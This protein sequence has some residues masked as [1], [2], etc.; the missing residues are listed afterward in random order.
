MINKTAQ[1]F[2]FFFL[3]TCGYGQVPIN[4]KH[5][6]VDDGLVSNRTNTVIKDSSGFMWFGTNTGLSR[7]DG[8]R[9]KTYSNIPNDR[10]SLLNNTVLNL[11]LGFERQLWVRTTKGNC[12]YDVMDDAFVWNT[13]SIL[14]A[15]GFVSGRVK[16]MISVEGATYILYESG[17]L[18]YASSKAGPRT[19]AKPWGG[20]LS[21]KITDV[22]MD[23]VRGM[24]LLVSDRGELMALDSEGLHVQQSLAFAFESLVENSDF[25]LFVDSF[26]GIWVY[27][28]NFPFG[29]LY[30]PTFGAAPE[31][32]RQHGGTVTV[33]NNYIHN[34]QQIDNTVWLATDHGGINVFDVKTRDIRYLQH[35]RLNNFSLPSNSTIT[36]YKDNDGMMWVGTYKGGV[37]YYHPSLNYF[38]LFQR[39]DGVPNS[40]PFNDVN[41]FEEDRKGIIWIG[42][43]GG[44]LVR[45]DP[46][47][48]SFKTYKH[49]SAD[50]HSIGSNVVVSLHIDMDG[51][52]WAGTYHGGLNK[53]VNGQFIRFLHSSRD[54]LSIND[55]SVWSILQDSKRRFWVGMLSGGIDLLDVSSFRFSRFKPKSPTDFHSS[56]NAKII[57]DRAGNI[58]IGT[59]HGVAKL[60]PEDHMQIYDEDTPD[61]P[62][63]NNV[64]SDLLE[65]RRGNIWIATQTGINILSADAIKYL[66]IHQ[67]LIDNVVVGLVMD[68]Y[69]DVWATT[70]KGISRISYSPQTDSYMVQ[71]FDKSDGLQSSNFNERAIYRLRDG[72]LLFGGSEGFNVYQPRP[73]TDRVS[74]S[75]PKIVDF[76]VAA[77]GM[78]DNQYKSLLKKW[79]R[80]SHE[81]KPIRVPHE[82]S[83][84]TALLSD[85]DFI[86]NHKAKVQYQ[87]K[88]LNEEWVDVED[89]EIRISNLPSGTY[90]LLLRSV[91]QKGGYSVPQKILGIRMAAPWYRTTWA[92][93]LYLIGIGSILFFLR[94]MEKMRARTK[95]QLM[96]I[97]E[98]ARHAKELE[99]L[100]TRF[101]TN[102]SHEFRTPISLIL[103][104]LANL[105]Q[106]ERDVTKIKYL[107]IIERNASSLLDLVNQLLDINK[108]DSHGHIQKPEFGGIV[109]LVERVAKQFESVAQEKGIDYTIEVPENEMETYLDFGKLERILLN[110]LSN[111]FKFTEAGHVG[112]RLVLEK[113]RR[114]I[115]LEVSDTGVGV[116]YEKQPFVFDRYYQVENKASATAK[117]S[118]L[119]L[120]IVKEFVQA[121]GGEVHFVSEPQKG[122]TVS[123]VLPLSNTLHSSISSNGFYHDADNPAKR[124]KDDESGMQSQKVLKVMVVEDNPDF[125]FY[126]RDNLQAYFHVR[127]YRRVD[128]AWKDILVFQPDIIVSDL[129][130][131]DHS[132][133]DFCRMVRRHERVKHIPFVLITAQG[134]EEKELEA[135]KEGVTDYIAKPFRFEVFLSK[136][137]GLLEQ[138]A[139]LEKRFKRQ[140]DVNVSRQEVVDEDERFVLELTAVIEEHLQ[141]EQFSVE[142]LASKMRMT[143]VGLYKKVVSLTGFTPI[144]YIRN[145]RLN[146]GLDLLK[147]SSL[148]VS[149]IAYRIGFGSP[150]Q[151]TKYFKSFY[152]DV[153]SAFRKGS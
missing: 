12:V 134:T 130:L 73:H 126:L 25:N 135:L 27:A 53:Y 112:V 64:V 151:F 52:L 129:N 88:G 152:G 125:S 105:K 148:T 139:L 91:D 62:L 32:F 96:Q 19:Q 84:F 58:W 115:L 18:Y 136:V 131:P 78:A 74:Q 35:D 43:N 92:Y 23:E 41:C 15:R 54:P 13:D 21:G 86:R 109:A 57:E 81:G 50:E 133:I 14:T 4:F 59:S 67:G 87:L 106:G 68:N 113:E 123:L 5:L 89:M 124:R 63:T 45:F 29:A 93:I 31:V 6:T 85:F 102:V 77:L 48:Q 10:S 42:T 70:P 95:F 138:K 2:L 60:S 30:Y 83:A 147:N 116:P 143:R 55:N 47:E 51:D 101:F 140:V 111:A 71:N 146:K 94:K 49:N 79:L 108:V 104:P 149:E 37:S 3:V 100:K 66:S 36:L 22:V 33:S 28:K 137:T 44:G 119:G 65:D 103:S 69:G 150:K 97:E 40:L 9:F 8:H 39:K 144:E 114:Q 20:K 120:A 46:H 132:G 17:T 110:L 16:K 121:M 118:G 1:T 99:E 145:V 127:T 122:T 82:L 80:S 34:I 38:S 128:E 61:Y 90:D 117:G 7:Y 11:F 107:D 24:L 75:L 141:D 56:Y 72:R 153:P 26:S 98:K 142:F 76:N